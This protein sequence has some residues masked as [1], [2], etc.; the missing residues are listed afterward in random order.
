MY[1]MPGKQAV[2]LFPTGQ[3]D[4][5]AL[6]GTLLS[7]EEKDGLLTD[8]HDKTGMQPVSLSISPHFS[9]CSHSLSAPLS[10]FLLSFCYPPLLSV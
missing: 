4:P 5:R 3:E 8:L 6:P 1:P 9:L 10:A 2:S 7:K